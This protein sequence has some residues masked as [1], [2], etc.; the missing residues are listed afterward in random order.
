MKY[1]I[2]S[3]TNLMKHLPILLT[4]VCGL[5]LA[6]CEQPINEQEQN[7][8]VNPATFS[9]V[10]K[11]YI[12]ENIVTGNGHEW[13]AVFHFASV[14][15]F[16]RWETYHLDDVLNSTLSPNAEWYKYALEYPDVYIYYGYTEEKMKYLTFTD[17]C[18]CIWGD[19][20]LKLN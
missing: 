7:Q 9:L 4:L 17:S 2:F 13:K 6:S 8:P 18:T 14:D 5:S 12:S 20:K 16:I 3:K 1:N 10:G 11:T 19:Y 15:S